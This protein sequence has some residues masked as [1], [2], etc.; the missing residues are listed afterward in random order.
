M[1]V[2]SALA[3]RDR[4]LHHERPQFG[5]RSRRIEPR[6]IMRMHSGRMRDV[7]GI[8]A[9]QECRIARG[10]EN[11]SRA[12]AGSDADYGAGPS[13]AGPLDYLVAVAGERRVGEVRVAV[14]EVWNAAVLRGHLRSI[15]NSTGAAT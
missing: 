8:T 9:R 13:D 7:T 1:V 10:G 4:V 14:D 12:T 5:N 6:R 15:H 2:E 3:D 11:I